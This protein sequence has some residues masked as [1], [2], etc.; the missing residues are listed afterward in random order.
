MRQ[1][2]N[3]S[4]RLAKSRASLGSF[5][6]WGLGFRFRVYGL[7]WAIPIPKGATL[8]EMSQSWPPG[9]AARS[10]GRTG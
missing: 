7:G 5:G 10:S 9:L 3:L 2:E 6:V 4:E 1:P 8:N